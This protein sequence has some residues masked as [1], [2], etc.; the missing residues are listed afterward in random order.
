DRS[1]RAEG[2]LERLL[3]SLLESTLDRVSATRGAVYLA[4]GDRVLKASVARPAGTQLAPLAR[5]EDGLV[6]LATD[7]RPRI[8]RAPSEKLRAEVAPLLDGSASL[9]L[10]PLQADRELLGVAVLAVDQDDA[11]QDAQ[12]PFLSL[13]AGQVALAVRNARAYL[14]SE[15]LAIGEERS[16]IARE[17]HDGVAQSLAFAAL[18]IDLG[19]KLID[20]DANRSRDELLQAA[21]TVREAIREVRRSIFALRPVTLE[22]FGFT[23]TVRR[24]LADFG[25]QNGVRVDL[26]LDDPGEIEVRVE[27]VLFRIFQEAMHNVAKHAQAGTVRVRI[28]RNEAGHPFVEVEDDGRG[29]DP[30]KVGRR[31]TSAGGLGLL[32]MRERVEGRGGRFELR[33]REGGGTVVRA[34]VP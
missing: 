25:P 4:D 17:I 22:R 7:G 1:I 21:E 29:F 14:H 27:A 9:V 11:V 24:Y 19:R 33:S 20:R 10:L 28:G 26:D 15:E 34:E 31:V 5:T 32:Q 16:R 23:E 6:A 3:G 8:V 2:N 18:K 13:L 12:L 30:H